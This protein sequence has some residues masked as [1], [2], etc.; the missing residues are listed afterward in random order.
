MLFR[1]SL[2]A[3]LL[4]L[5]T[6]PAAAA[7]FKLAVEAGPKTGSG[8]FGIADSALA[9][10]GTVLFVSADFQFFDFTFDGITFNKSSALNPGTEGVSVSGGTV[11]SFAGSSFA[12]FGS[13]SGFIS[14]DVNS[15]AFFFVAGRETTSGTYDISAQP[16]P[17]PAALT[18]LLSGLA[19]VAGLRM[20]QRRKVQA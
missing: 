11:S 8:T 15:R 9:S 13:P 1:S 4:S 5:V 12:Q 6:L 14:F 17:L 10:D 3:A 20:R 18:L 7:T 16:V 2:F 19:G